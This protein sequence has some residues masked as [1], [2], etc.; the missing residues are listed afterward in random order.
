MKKIISLVL[1]LT[2]AL[3]VSAMVFADT[4]VCELN[5]EQWA[6]V[7]AF[8]SDFVEDEL[9]AGDI[10][11]AEAADLLEKLENRES[12][13]VLKELGFGI[14][15]RDTGNYDEIS[16]IVSHKNMNDSQGNMNEAKGNQE[17]RQSNRDDVN[18]EYGQGRSDEN[19][20]S[21]GNRFN[22]EN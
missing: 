20:E 19:F 13:G 14:W 4:E 5:D 1:V 17:L 11:E 12:M 8:K 21:K 9:T 2:M 15:L 7:F 22:S 16:T 3:G 18:F 10:T 6:S